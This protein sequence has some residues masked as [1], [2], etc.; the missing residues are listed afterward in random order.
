[1]DIYSFIISVLSFL[2]M[3]DLHEKRGKKIGLF[4]NNLHLFL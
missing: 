3:I 2:W 4:I 1:M